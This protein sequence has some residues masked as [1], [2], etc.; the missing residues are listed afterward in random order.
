MQFAYQFPE[1]C[2]RL[3]LVSSGGLGQ[4]VNLLLARSRSRAPS[5][6]CR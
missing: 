2:E 1:R 6:C 4:E 5:T 3:A